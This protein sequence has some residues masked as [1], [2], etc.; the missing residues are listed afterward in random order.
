MRIATFLVTADRS[1]PRSNDTQRSYKGEILYED[2]YLFN[3]DFA[4]QVRLSALT[5]DFDGYSKFEVGGRV[6]LSRQVTDKY[7]IGLVYSARHVEITDA[8]IKQP[9]ARPHFIFRQLDRFYPDARPAQE[10]ARRAARVC[11]R[12]HPGFRLECD[13]Q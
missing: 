2:P 7:S 10:P 1:R 12:Q 6:T 3:T 13:R 9:I 8:S 11:F 5:F 4:L